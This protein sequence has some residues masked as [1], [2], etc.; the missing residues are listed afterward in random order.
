MGPR[1][2]ASRIVGLLSQGLLTLR[3]LLQ[4]VLGPLEP[5]S[6][7]VTEL[8]RQRG[9]FPEAAPNL[10]SRLKRGLIP[11]VETPDLVGV[12]LPV[13]QP[14]GEFLA[15]APRSGPVKE[16][17]HQFFR[18][19]LRLGSGNCREADE[20]QASNQ[21]NEPQEGRS[22]VSFSLQPASQAQQT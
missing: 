16:G 1:R 4:L 22:H 7:L 5:G 20:D 19:C 17:R 15:T 13:V 11:N 6:S 18:G 14:P 10:C 2:T 3:P 21:T 8:S 12:M 9:I